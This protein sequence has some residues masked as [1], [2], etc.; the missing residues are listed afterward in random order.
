LTGKLG[1]WRS[2]Y[3]GTINDGDL[4]D[5]HAIATGGKLQY[6][7]PFRTHWK[8][9]GTIYVTFNT[10]IQDLTIP[11]PATG[12]LSRYEAGLFDVQD[13]DDPLIAFPGELFVQYTHRDHQVA[14]GRIK[15]VTPFINPQDGRMIPTLTQ[16]IWYTYEPKKWKLKTGLEQSR[17]ANTKL[18]SELQFMIKDFYHCSC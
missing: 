10:S 17:P 8:F 6:V 16:G 1:Q 14:L 9:G 4:K 15:L 12:R 11:D 7:R 2:Y 3:L 5:F 13:L 18:N